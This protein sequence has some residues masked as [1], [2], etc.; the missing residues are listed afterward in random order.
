[1]PEATALS[2]CQLLGASFPPS[3]SNLYPTPQ[4]VFS[5][6]WPLFSHGAQLRG[7][8]FY[9]T[10]LA[11]VNSVRSEVPVPGALVRRFRGGGAQPRKTSALGCVLPAQQLELVP[12]APD[13][14][15]RPLAAVFPRSPAPWEPFLSDRPGGSQFRQVRGPGSRGT[16]TPL[17]RRRGAAPQNVSS[18]VRPS[19]P[20]ARTCIPRPRRSSAPTGR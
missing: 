9:L 6:H 2:L 8:P 18:W 7:S 3:S 5:A 16:R 15:Q 4:T 12:Y 14:L 11:E 19:R 17:P 10:D 20:A 13:G 1:M